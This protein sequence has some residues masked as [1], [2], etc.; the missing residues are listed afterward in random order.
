MIKHAED[1]IRY[2]DSKKNHIDG[3]RG[4]YDSRVCLRRVSRSCKS[5][6]TVVTPSSLR[7]ASPKKD[8]ADLEILKRD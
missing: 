3:G 1:I 8:L 6:A 5:R 2:T 7:G 4:C